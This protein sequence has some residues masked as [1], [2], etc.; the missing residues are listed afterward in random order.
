MWIMSA[1]PRKSAPQG[2][3]PGVE[4]DD[5]NQNLTEGV[6][7]GPEVALAKTMSQG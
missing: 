2:L 1:L 6:E 7:D 4:G 5:E 3:E